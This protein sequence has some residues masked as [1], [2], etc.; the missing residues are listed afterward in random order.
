MASDCSIIKRQEGGLRNYA[1]AWLWACHVSALNLDL[2]W[3]QSRQVLENQGVVQV[4][5]QLRIQ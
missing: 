5:F 3:N 2:C 1:P 4:S